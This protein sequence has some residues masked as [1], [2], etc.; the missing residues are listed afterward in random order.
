MIE[1]C[2]KEK[3]EMKW[4]GGGEEGKVK[5]ENAG[6]YSGGTNGKSSGAK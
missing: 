4:N 6:R 5:M 1:R 3:V 2:S